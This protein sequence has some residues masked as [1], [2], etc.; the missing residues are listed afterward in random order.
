MLADTRLMHHDMLTQCG[1]VIRLREACGSSC[2]ISGGGEAHVRGTAGHPNDP[3]ARAFLFERAS[4]VV[5]PPNRTRWARKNWLE[6]GYA[7]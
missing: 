3:R 6:R 7:P 1:K 2:S 4:C 5:V